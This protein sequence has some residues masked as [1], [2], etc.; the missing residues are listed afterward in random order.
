MVRLV[1]V[2]IGL[3]IA[4]ILEELD[5]LQ[6]VKHAE[7][8]LNGIIEHI[9]LFLLLVDILTNGVPI[10]P[11]DQPQLILRLRFVILLLNAVLFSLIREDIQQI[12]LD[13]H[14]KELGLTLRQKF[15][16]QAI[17]IALEIAKSQLDT[18]LIYFLE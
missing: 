12:L 18:F 6:N 14:P 10:E 1:L 11:F 4:T 7:D 13:D 15:P 5:L 8:I 17:I 9:G 16:D 2:C 3:F